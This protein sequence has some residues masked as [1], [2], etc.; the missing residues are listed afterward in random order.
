MVFGYFI[1]LGGIAQAL[2]GIFFHKDSTRAFHRT[3]GRAVL[4]AALLLQIPSGIGI[5]FSDEKLV[6]SL[7]GTWTVY[8][9]V[10]GVVY[11][12]ALAKSS[13]ES[14]RTSAYSPPA[15]F[16]GKGRWEDV[17]ETI[18][19]ALKKN[20]YT[21]GVM[22]ARWPSVVMSL[23]GLLA[24][25]CMSG[26][27]ALRS[28]TSIDGWLPS[29]T[30]TISDMDY[31]NEWF[32]ELDY[33]KCMSIFL[34]KDTSKNI[35]TKDT[36]FDMLELMDKIESF[37]VRTSDLEP[38][39]ALVTDYDADGTEFCNTFQECCRR[40]YPG[41]TCSARSPLDYWKN[42]FYE[43]DRITDEDV[44]RHVS[45]PNVILDELGQAIDREDV[46]GG[47]THTPA[48]S[49]NITAVE[50]MLMEIH[51]SANPEWALPFQTGILELFH[52]QPNDGAY[53]FLYYCEASYDTELDDAISGDVPLFGLA[54]LTMILFSAVVMGPAHP[55]RGKIYVSFGGVGCIFLG[56]LA[57]M[58]F[59]AMSTDKYVRVSRR[60]NHDE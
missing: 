20:Y 14:A 1:L 48:H 6:A 2:V 45:N 15:W 46:L 19:F 10:L 26:L 5:G 42:N 40:S 49:N 56:L 43:I 59:S 47:I 31:F 16:D 32:S 18:D 54:F 36:L 9:L 34:A 13:L 7:L 8:V 33:V 57:G 11:Y 38:V 23:M 50:A 12:S 58:G 52:A 41:A 37:D 55:L 35:L 17:T 25:C 21:L 27:M 4:G 39:V 24:I 60:R 51:F 29:G 3:L 30:Q 22:V 28:D 53:D 44:L